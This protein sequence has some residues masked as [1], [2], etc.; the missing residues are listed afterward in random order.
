[1]CKF[2]ECE[3]DV[4]LIAF[5]GRNIQGECEDELCED[6]LFQNQKENTT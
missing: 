1:M 4:G 6:G 3:I 2:V 5:G